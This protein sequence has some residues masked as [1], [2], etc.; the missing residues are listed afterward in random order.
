MHDIWKLV[1]RE[2]EKNIQLIRNISENKMNGFE[3]I[4][5]K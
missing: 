3:W 4:Q 2:I 1:A 5:V